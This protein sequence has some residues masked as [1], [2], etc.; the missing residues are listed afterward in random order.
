MTAAAPPPNPGGSDDPQ[1]RQLVTLPRDLPY[2]KERQKLR[3]K[4]PPVK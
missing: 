1:K 2:S 4:D 3:R